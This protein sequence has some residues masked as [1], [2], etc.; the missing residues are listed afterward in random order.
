[1]KHITYIFLA[2]FSSILLYNCEEDTNESSLS[3]VTFG[4]ASYSA[5]VDVGGETTVDIPI[6]TSNITGNDRTFSLSIDGT[7]ASDN[8][9]T[10]PQTVT[11]PGG[12][13]KGVLSINLSDVNLGIGINKVIVNFVADGTVANIGDGTT[14]NYYQIC[15]EVTLTLDLAFDSYPE[16]A[17]W[18]IQNSLGDVIASVEEGTYSGMSTASETIS[19]CG[20]RDFIFIL[21]D[22]Y[23]DGGHTFSLKLDGVVIAQVTQPYSYDSSIS[24]PFETK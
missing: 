16:E 18:E 10:V 23:G 1:M 11:V 21:K 17:Y 15:N 20:D 4:N 7:G 3:Y 19:I 8:S 13:N 5:G 6:Y 9:Y 14:I 12:T 2:I 24:T 22:S